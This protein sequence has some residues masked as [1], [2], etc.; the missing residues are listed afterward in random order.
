MQI[1]ARLNREAIL[2]AI[3]RATAQRADSAQISSMPTID[4]DEDE[5]MAA[6][7]AALTFS[8]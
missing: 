7:A 4:V 3:R 1:Y 6:A 2:A 5:A 8:G